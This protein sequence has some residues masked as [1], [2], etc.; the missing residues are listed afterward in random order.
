MRI[1]CVSLLLFFTLLGLNIRLAAHVERTSKCKYIYN[2]NATHPVCCCWWG[3]RIVSAVSSFDC[4][5]GNITIIKWKIR[6]APTQC[7]I[8]LSFFAKLFCARKGLH[9]G[10]W[11]AIENVL[12]LYERGRRA[13]LEIHPYKCWKF[14]TCSTNYIT[15]LKIRFVLPISSWQLAPNN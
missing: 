13:T 14:A 9:A 1:F 6:A 2:A 11:S 4:C 15:T 3:E 7:Y 12:R 5:A 10:C 8:V